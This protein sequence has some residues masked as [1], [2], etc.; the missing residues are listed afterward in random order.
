MQGF[1]LFA[2]GSERIRS[3][4]GD[5]EALSLAIRRFQDSGLSIPKKYEHLD[6]AEFVAIVFYKAHSD[7][8]RLHAT[9]SQERLTFPDQEKQIKD[10]LNDYEDFFAAVGVQE[11]FIFIHGGHQEYEDFKRS[12]L[13]ARND[14]WDM[15]DRDFH[16]DFSA[17]K[18]LRAFPAEEDDV[19]FSTITTTFYR[20]SGKIFRQT[21]DFKLA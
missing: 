3:D 16:L 9:I 8:L 21:V 7:I 19:R 13:Y 15:K 4:S 10:C 20:P 6:I 11:C 17:K 18:I 2:A 1:Y 12:W 5:H 14:F